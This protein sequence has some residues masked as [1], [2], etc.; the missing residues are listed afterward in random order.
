VVAAGCFP[1]VPQ[2]ATWVQQ[3]WDLHQR[4]SQPERRT[5]TWLPSM[6]LIVRRDAFVKIG[7]FNEELETAEDV[8][9]CYR[10]GQHGMILCNPAMEATHWGE[11]WNLRSFFRKEAWRGAGNLKGISVHGLRWDELPSIGYPLYVLCCALLFSLSVGLDAWRGQFIIIP[12]TFILLVLPALVLAIQASYRTKQLRRTLP[13]FALYLTYGLA[14]AY[15]IVKA[16]IS[17]GRFR[18]SRV[19]REMWVSKLLS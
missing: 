14:R 1:S 7:G 6:N 9:L 2:P 11:A 18:V 19:R 17:W 4:G 3:T 8:D 13:L 12:L 10:L 5:V 16:G 15:S